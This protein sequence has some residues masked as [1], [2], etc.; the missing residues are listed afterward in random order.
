MEIGSYPLL[1]SDDGWPLCYWVAADF[2]GKKGE[3][4]EADVARAVS[5]LLDFDGCPCFVNLSRSGLGAH[6]RMLFKEPVPAWAARRWLNSW[7]EEAGV[8][9]DVWDE[10]IPSAFDRLIPPQDRLTGRMDMNG[11]RMPG[12]LIGSPLHGGLGRSHGGTIPLDPHR[13]AD[14][15]FT[16]DG[17]HWHHVMAA[18]E[19]RTWGPDELFASMRDCPTEI[20][21]VPPPRGNYGNGQVPLPVAGSSSELFV[22]LNFCEF[23]R[24]MAS[25]SNQNYPLWVSLATQ[26]HRF[27]DDGLRAFH[28]L[29]RGHPDYDPR[30]TDL[31][32]DQTVDLHPVRCDT[33]T[34]WG[35]TCPLLNKP[36]CGAAAPSFFLRDLGVYLR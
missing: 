29:S 16:P 31:K 5:F 12:N 25:P 36:E 32:W 27:G 28:A 9:R 19:A 2:D 14:Q 30:D 10:E 20:A 11:H 1:P 7:L 21:V 34:R 4:W 35:F 15:D 8:L 18:L 3:A 13:V 23:M 22:V 26:L 33:M 24:H 17:R 6:V